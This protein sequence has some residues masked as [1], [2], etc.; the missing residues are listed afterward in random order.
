M[1]AL[2]KKAIKQMVRAA[3]E[4]DITPDW[5]D[6]RPPLLVPHCIPRPDGTQSLCGFA[7]DPGTEPYYGYRPTPE[8]CCFVC[9]DI[10]K[11]TTGGA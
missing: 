5:F 11:S 4:P 1:E 3:L 6:P 9:W 10:Y 7:T 8:M 2:S